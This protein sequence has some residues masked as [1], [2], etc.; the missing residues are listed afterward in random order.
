MKKDI[1]A[2]QEN[3]IIIC[4]SKMGRTYKRKLAGNGLAKRTSASMPMKM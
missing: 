1:R 4:K 2:L 3:G